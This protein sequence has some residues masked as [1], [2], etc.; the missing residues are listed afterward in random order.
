VDSAPAS[1]PK[2]DFTPH[3]EPDEAAAAGRRMHALIAALYP[4]CRSMTGDGVRA[5]LRIVRD[6]IG[7]GIKEVPTGT[8]VFDWTV[9]QE[10]NIE[11]AY[12][13]GPDGR[14]IVDFGQ[15]NL[16]V[17]GYSAPVRRKLP[18]RELRR[19]LH[20]LPDKPSWIPYRTSYFKD[21]WGFCLSHDQ[22]QS[23]PDGEY[24][25]VIDSTLA[26]GSLTYGELLVEGET[27]DE[28]LISCHVCHPSLCN[29]N[30]SG[31][32]LAV[33]LAERLAAFRLRYSYRFVYIP[34]TIGSIA[35][36]ALN[37]AHVSRIRHGLVIA[38]GGDAGDITYK[39]SR[40]GDALIDRTMQVVLRD[41]G[42]AHTIK[43]FIPFGYDERQYCSPGFDL[44]VG[45]FSRSP[46]GSYPEYHT[47]ADNL[48]FVRP[49]ALAHSFTT[50]LAA[51]GV[52]ESNRRYVNLNPR[53]EPQLGRRGIYRAWAERPDGGGAEMALLWVLN[54]AGGG[55]DLL[56]IAERSALP[57]A[58]IR[59]AAEV[60]A[61]C[62]LI[63]VSTTMEAEASGR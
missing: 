55:A 22:L 35:W 25:A 51:V 36:L 26:D 10:W 5:T 43:D 6:R 20:S 60:L 29:D 49:E 52:L 30:L 50:L 17:V 62:G 33:A 31:I 21:S 39:K 47:S 11:D 14:K 61:A 23:L 1:E 63:S 48:E 16:H 18:L 15:S 19:H 58:S 28:V 2:P 40:R 46:Y 3:I 13:K 32:A 7:L 9:P 27:K 4:I 37:E 24:E 38:N 59:K 34:A 57:Y 54:M 53:C 45:C 42:Q 44:P 41:L 12:I 56:A 8:K